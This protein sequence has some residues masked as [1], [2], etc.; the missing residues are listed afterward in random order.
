VVPKARA[1]E[2]R[3]R[4]QREGTLR[5]DLKVARRGDEVLLPLVRPVE[6]GF[7][8]AEEEFVAL[9]PPAGDYRSH[10]ELPE[11]LRPHLPSSFDVV[12]RV[13]I[14]KLPEELVPHRR[15]VGRAVLAAHPNLRS[16]TL[17]RG[18]EGEYRVRR[19]E[20]IA[21][22]EDLETVH[23]EYGVP[24]LVDPSK[25]YF[26]PRLATERWRVTRL[27]APGEVVLDLFA[28]V[29]P[30]AILIAKH[31][32]PRRVLAVDANPHAVE[33][34]RRNVELNGVAEVVEP[35]GGDALNVASRVGKVDR[36]ILDFPHDPGRFFGASLAAAKDGTVVHYYEIAPREGAKGRGEAIRHTAESAGAKVAV[37]DPREVRPYSPG[38]AHFAWDVRVTSAP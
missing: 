32:S 3:R 17:D 10:A 7:P 19:L 4:L 37:P 29:G 30:W 33:Y 34:L 27:V 2:V 35:L 36:I 23:R 12:G 25:A 31:R 38:Q 14:I 22:G 15:I 24:L 8:T 9:P 6:L 18:V 11:D 20:V 28:G 16:V 1:E 26:S 5:R 21:G 13:A